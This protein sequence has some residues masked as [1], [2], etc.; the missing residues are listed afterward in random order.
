MSHPTTPNS[1]AGYQFT[2]PVFSFAGFYN[3]AD[4]PAVRWLRRFEHELSGYANE[5]G[6]I[7]PKKYISSLA[8]LLRGNAADWAE[9][10]P[11]ASRVFNLISPE[12]SDVTNI[13]NQ[14][15]ERFPAKSTDTVAV[16]FNVELS[17]LHQK[18]DDSIQS[19]YNGTLN[20]MQR[21]GAKD[22]PID[23][24]YS[25]LEATVLDNVVRTFVKGLADTDVRRDAYKGLGRHDYSLKGVYIAA[26]EARRTKAE[27]SK[28]LEEESK[29]KELNILR[30]MVRGLP[31]T[32][33]EALK[34][35]YAANPEGM[36]S[37][38]CDLHTIPRTSCAPP[39]QDRN[40]YV[41][42]LQ[43]PLPAD[44]SNRPPLAPT[45]GNR[46]YPKPYSK[47]LPDRSESKNPFI[48]GTL[49]WRI[50]RDGVLCVKC[51]ELDHTGRQ[52]PNSPLPSWEKAYLRALVF[53][54]EPQ[55]SFVEASFGLYDGACKPW[56]HPDNKVVNP[57]T[58]Q[59]VS[60]F[61]PSSS[62]HPAQ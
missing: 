1:M 27:V 20:L 6:E 41:P 16:P 30:S 38:I 9:N 7:P 62:L 53:G 51:G 4:E 34:T 45:T 43:D 23:G 54:D 47:P 59:H 18:T 17:D 24:S 26:E 44:Q 8:L 29:E 46:G 60:Q 11:E 5:Q 36:A 61:T 25:P 13:R 12:K 33:V 22:H 49:E 40:L 37:W 57:T 52:C 58:L 21:I 14:L 31:P 2:G 35:A 39:V 56:G 28:L 55:A 32:Q 3:G 19:Y 10:H 48:N 50:D 42:P 15:Q